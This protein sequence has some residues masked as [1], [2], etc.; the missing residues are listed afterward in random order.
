VLALFRYLI[1]LMS[2]FDVFC[3]CCTGALL[4]TLAQADTSW[5]KPKVF[6]ELGRGAFMSQ[7][8]KPGLRAQHVEMEDD[9]DGSVI[10][11]TVSNRNC[12]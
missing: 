7:I 3:P 5:M 4:H 1:L 6:L 10:D 9:R 2:P 12:G 11:P 8:S